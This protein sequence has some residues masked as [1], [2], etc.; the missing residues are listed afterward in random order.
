MKLAYIGGG[1][2]KE[3]APLEN[4]D[5]DNNDVENDLEGTGLLDCTDVGSVED[6]DGLDVNSNYENEDQEDSHEHDFDTDPQE[7]MSTAQPSSD[8]EQDLGE[9]PDSLAK[10][11]IVPSMSTSNDDSHEHLNMNNPLDLLKQIYDV[12]AG[13]VSNDSDVQITAVSIP[14]KPI[15]TIVGKVHRS[16]SYQCYL[17]GF[18]A[19]M[20]VTFVKHFSN[21]HPN[22]KFKCDFCNNKFDSCNGL[23][24]H[25]RSHQYLHYK[26][27]F[28][29]HR[30][31]FPYQMDAHSK[32]HTKKGLEKCDLCEKHF[33]SKASKKSH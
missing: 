10:Q 18:K 14:D 15:P 16:C 4:T 28:C 21:D 33:M 30:T 29:G 3:I 13:Y 5:D 2:Y 19:E 7:S 26:C 22:D 27:L 32:T 23:F 12:D 17:C 6:D 20:Q 11:D 1:I 9:L 31:Q 24:K 25:E 8:V